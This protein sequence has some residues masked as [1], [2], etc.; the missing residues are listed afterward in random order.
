MVT[1]SDNKSKHSETI[2]GH[3]YNKEMAESLGIE[4]FKDYETSIAI[5]DCDGIDHEFEV[6]KMIH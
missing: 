3:C 2:C 4:D 6:R 1:I 5:K